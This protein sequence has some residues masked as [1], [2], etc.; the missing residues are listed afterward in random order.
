MALL[1]HP[2]DHGLEVCFFILRYRNMV[3]VVIK[4]TTC[5]KI[6]Q[7]FKFTLTL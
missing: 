3:E 4:D 7:L 5:P 6:D 1:A 2:G